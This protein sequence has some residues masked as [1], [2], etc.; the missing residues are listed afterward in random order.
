MRLVLYSVADAIT[1]A[2]QFAEKVAEASSFPEE[3][4]D[5]M[6]LSIGEAVANSIR[7]G[8]NSDS[9]KKI[10]LT[11]SPEPGGG[12]LGVEDEG[13]GIS[14]E[15][16]RRAVLPEDAYQ[17]GGRGLFII[18]ELSDGFRV[19]D[20]GNRLLLWFEPRTSENE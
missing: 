16:I 6:V 13:A 12:W 9:E 18:R 14:E 4:G 8:N 11:W 3:V 5:R 15:Q 20:G 17:T 7:H 19:E 1:R 2:V 10:T